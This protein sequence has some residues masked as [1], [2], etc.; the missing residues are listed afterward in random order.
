M[1][2][3]DLITR[4]ANW[5]KYEYPPQGPY[6]SVN[7]YADLREEGIISDDDGLIRFV[8]IN[9]DGFIVEV[10]K[11]PHNSRAIAVAFYGK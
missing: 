8:I 3:H 11:V 6:V 7:E 2:E 1:T 10:D 5:P 9:A 4:P